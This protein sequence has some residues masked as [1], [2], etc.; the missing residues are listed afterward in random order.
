MTRH[1]LIALMVVAASAVGADLPDGWLVV[2]GGT[3]QRITDVRPMLILRSREGATSAVKESARGTHGAWRCLVQPSLGTMACGI[4]FQASRD[5]STGF[6]CELGGNPGVGGFA[7][8]NADGKVL[9]ADEW[10]P[11]IPYGAYVL[12][13]IIEK[14]RVRVQML[15]YDGTTL[16][17]QSDWVTTRATNT[18]RKGSLGVYTENGIARFWGAE[19]SETPLCPMTDDAPNKRRLVQSKNSEWVLFGTGNWM[20]TDKHKVRVRQYARTERAWALNRSIRG[21]RAI[22]QCAVRVHPGAGGAGMIFQCDMKCRGGFNCWLGGKHGAGGLMLYHNGG[23]GK[24]GQALWSS[25]QDKW[26]YDEDLMLHAETEGA[27]VRVRLLAG[28]GKTTIAESRWIDV[29][30]KD[31]K[32]RGYMA[33][34]TWRGSV[35]FWGFSGTTQAAS[36]VRPTA[37]AKPELGPGWVVAGDGKWVW[38]DKGK[39]ALRQTAQARSTS[40]LNTGVR[41]TRGAWRCVVKIAEGTEAAG[42]L[43]QADE[44]LREGFLCMLTPGRLEFH[45]LS[46]KGGPRW[47]D[48]ECKWETGRPYVLEGLVQTDRIAVR[49]LAADGKSLISESPEVYVSDQNNERRGHI[50]FTTRGGPAE[51]SSWSFVAEH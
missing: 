45:D 27:K 37:K 48:A 29:P 34:H 12:E 17:S 36:T 4:W 24:R 38:Q 3:W 35:E 33:F 28:D 50:G 26:H 49:L 51:F 30:E 7:L 8:K 39:S 41:G 47:V 43:F 32:R 20:W 18:D 31:A 15:G 11:W 19:R 5:L 21:P 46:Q 42:L 1:E 13:G 44:K 40:C 10:A 23:P 14:G 9:W 6:R 25:K 2:G 16:I 22:W